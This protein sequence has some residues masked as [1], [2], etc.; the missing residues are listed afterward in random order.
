[1]KAVCSWQTKHTLRSQKF[2]FYSLAFTQNFS[3][4]QPLAG[5]GEKFYTISSLPIFDEA[6]R[7]G[8]S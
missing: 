1:L 8:I 5:Y 7:L 2:F 3:G 6:R 4:Y